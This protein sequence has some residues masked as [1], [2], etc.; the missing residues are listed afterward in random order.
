MNHRGTEITEIN[1]EKVIL[2]VLGTPFEVL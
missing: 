2:V 1:T